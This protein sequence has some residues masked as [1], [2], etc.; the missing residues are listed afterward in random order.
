MLA[1]VLWRQT[2][3]LPLDYSRR[4]QSRA[5]RT[6]GL[7]S[8]RRGAGRALL[9]GSLSFMSSWVASVQEV[10]VAAATAAIAKVMTALQRPSLSSS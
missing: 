7:D 5:R 6:E 3:V 4:S 1:H 9:V 2:S 10:A 8:R